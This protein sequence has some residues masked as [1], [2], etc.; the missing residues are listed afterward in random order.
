MDLF[1]TKKKSLNPFAESDEPGATTY[2]FT[3]SG[4]RMTL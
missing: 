3:G 1:Y 4:G 2:R